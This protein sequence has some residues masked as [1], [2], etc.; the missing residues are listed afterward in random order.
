MERKPPGH[1]LGALQAAM[2]LV[3]DTKQ[4]QSGRGAPLGLYHH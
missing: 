2:T 1:V 4:S 3:L